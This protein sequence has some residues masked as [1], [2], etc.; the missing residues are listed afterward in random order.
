MRNYYKTEQTR[1]M[2]EAGNP[3]ELSQISA[4]GFANRYPLT[5]LLGL[6]DAFDASAPLSRFFRN[7]KMLSRMEPL[8][9]L[10]VPRSSAN[11]YCVNNI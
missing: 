4:R 5:L 7:G 9:R 10:L 6:R 1:T 8:D 3:P 11:D 2:R